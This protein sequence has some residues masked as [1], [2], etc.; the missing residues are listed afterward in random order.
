MAFIDCNKALC[1]MSIIIT[2]VILLFAAIVVT[3][4][5]VRSAVPFD[6][7]KFHVVDASL[8]E[9]SLS[10][11]EMLRYNLTLGISIRNSNKKLSVSYTLIKATTFCYGKNFSSHDIGVFQQAHKTTTL[12]R[13]VFQG[14]SLLVLT[15][16]EP[17]DFN[18]DQRDGNF[19][20]HLK[21]DIAFELTTDGEVKGH[22]YRSKVKCGLRI[23]L[24]N[25]SSDIRLGSLFST[26]KCKLDDIVNLERPI[27][28]W[29]LIPH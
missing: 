7:M 20:I 8:T 19:N 3:L 6:N 2:T 16:S 13:S 26:K 17:R 25:S 10:N 4:F 11:D 12:V 27:N 22:P 15:G 28:Y 9:F 29:L 5:L 14:H 24:L 18:D 1:W 21:L 23:P